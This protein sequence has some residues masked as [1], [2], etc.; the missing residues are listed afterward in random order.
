MSLKLDDVIATAGFAADPYPYYRELQEH[1]PV[2]WSERWNCWV[3]TRYEDVRACLQDFHR[4][5]NVGRITGLFH[6]Q[7]DANQLAALQ[8]LIA[9]YAQGLINV[10]P[11]AH[12]RI[13]KLLHE[14]FK[15]STIAR[16]A[17]HVRAFV[18]EL[19]AARR[20]ANRLDVVR[21]LAHPLPVQVIAELFGVPR[22]D[23]PRFTRWSAEIVRFMQSPQP[24]FAACLQSQAALLELRAYLR[25]AI[26]ARRAEARDD[27]LSLMVHARSEGDALTEEEILGTSVT[28]LLGG[29]ETT[30]RLMATT[31]HELARHPGEVARLRT[32]PGLMETAVEEFLRFCGPFHRDQRV[33]IADTSVGGRTVRRGEYLLLMLAAANRDPRQ[34]PAPDTF[35]LAR[36][37]NRHLAFGFG[38]H[39]CLGAHLARLEMTEAIRTLLAQTPHLR[40]VGGPTEWE[41]GFLRG[42]RELTLDLQP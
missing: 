16:L 11:P 3:V 20:D 38:P 7:F 2:Q 21:E 24:A 37:P 31:I 32:E 25:E 36:K 13:R 6:R 23:A 35:D 33:V 27:V 42:P 41:L 12:T 18:T 8:P 15:P 1:D 34:F 14:V 10:D 17:A 5:S 40:L 30:T 29:H 26:A 19:L 39:I 28:L 9:H 22:G 4:F